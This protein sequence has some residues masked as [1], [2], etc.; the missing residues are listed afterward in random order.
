MME[1][2]TELFR[3]LSTALGFGLAVLNYLTAQCRA[4]EKGDRE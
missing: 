3:L 1:F 2:A 4:K